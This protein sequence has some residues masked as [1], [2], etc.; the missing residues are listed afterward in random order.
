MPRRKS[1][2]NGLSMSNAEILEAA[3]IGLGRQR[4]EIAD[5]MEELRRQIGDGRRGRP[6]KTSA[7]VDSVVAPKKRTMSSAGRRRIAAAQRKRWAALKQAEEPEP[8]KKKRRMSAAGRARIVAAT[9]KRWAEFRKKKA[10]VGKKD[11][12]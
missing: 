3:L 5:K 8:A 9:K 11:A 6:S 10:T 2:F 4:S 7:S 12:A 1:T